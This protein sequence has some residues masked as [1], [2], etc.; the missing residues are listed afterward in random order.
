MSLG[1]LL[2]LSDFSRVD[3]MMDSCPSDRRTEFSFFGGEPLLRFDLIKEIVS[4]IYKKVSRS[5]VAT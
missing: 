3:F 2:G 5:Q 1:A 4:Y